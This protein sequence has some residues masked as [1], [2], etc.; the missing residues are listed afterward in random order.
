MAGHGL[1]ARL[2]YIENRQAS[3]A[4]GEAVFINNALPIGSPMSD[5]EEEFLESGLETLAGR[6]AFR[7]EDAD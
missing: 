3:M 5:I 1:D 7:I 4:E 6:P 2:A